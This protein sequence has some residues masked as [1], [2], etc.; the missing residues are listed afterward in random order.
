MPVQVRLRDANL[1]FGDLVWFGSPSNV[2]RHHRSP[3]LLVSKAQQTRNVRTPR[4]RGLFGRIADMNSGARYGTGSASI[5]FLLYSENLMRRW[6]L[7][8]GFL[9]CRP[10]FGDCALECR[11]VQCARD[12]EVADDE[13]GCA[14]KAECLRL[15]VIPR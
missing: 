11:R 7:G 5:S 15:R 2:F 1:R 10:R 9:G 8:L 6:G 13:G 3:A 4:C 14:L 12:A